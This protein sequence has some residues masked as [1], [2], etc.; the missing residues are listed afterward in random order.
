MGF[1][2]QV[3]GQTVTWGGE[4]DK[5]YSRKLYKP[6]RSIKLSE[7]R[8]DE[9]DG[10]LSRVFIF[11]D[12]KGIEINRFDL[13]TSFWPDFLLE[14]TIKIPEGEELIGFAIST[15]MYQDP[16]NHTKTDEVIEYISFTCI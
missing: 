8:S 14:K 12:A 1:E 11:Y 10:E 9:N 6:V 5:S 15:Y 7:H 4:G 16:Y 2:W 3:G 13:W